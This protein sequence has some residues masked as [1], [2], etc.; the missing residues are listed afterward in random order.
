MRL[1]FVRLLFIVLLYS[2]ACG[3]ILAYS[4]DEVKLS[5]ISFKTGKL[6]TLFL[7]ESIFVSNLFVSLMI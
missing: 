6:E 2:N 4:W 1:L 5:R 7:N 3:I